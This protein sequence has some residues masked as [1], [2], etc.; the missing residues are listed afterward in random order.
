MTH[1]KSLEQINKS[2]I[3]ALKL[4]GRTEGRASSCQ[5]PLGSPWCREWCVRC[6]VSVCLC[7]TGR[8][9]PRFIGSQRRSQQ[10][11]SACPSIPQESATTPPEVP[12]CRHAVGRTNPH[13]RPDQ[14]TPWV[15]RSNGALLYQGG[16]GLLVPQG[17]TTLA[18]FPLTTELSQNLNIFAIRKWWWKPLKLKYGLKVL[19]LDFQRCLFLQ[20]VIKSLFFPAFIRHDTRGHMTRSLQIAALELEMFWTSILLNMGSNRPSKGNTATK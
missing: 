18:V 15:G 3:L 4:C 7:A 10:R 5:K 19:M 13:L 20:S 12:S 8:C 2:W 17:Q 14:F 1:F 16:K 9:L 6:R 11:A